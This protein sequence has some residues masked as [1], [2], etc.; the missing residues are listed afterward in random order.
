MMYSVLIRI[1]GTAREKYL[2]TFMA[3]A[4]QTIKP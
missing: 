1:L 4:D 3:M 2:Q